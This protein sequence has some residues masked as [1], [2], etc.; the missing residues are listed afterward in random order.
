MKNVE[1]KFFNNIDLIFFQQFSVNVGLTLL[2][3]F[4]TFSGNVGPKIFRNVDKTLFNN[5]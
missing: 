3:P 2:K 5:F 1:S 4:S